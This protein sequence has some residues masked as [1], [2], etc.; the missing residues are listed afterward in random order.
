MVCTMQVGLD[1][2]SVELILARVWDLAYS[3]DC[4][5]LHGLQIAFSG[6]GGGIA[7]YKPGAEPQGMNCT[8]FNIYKQ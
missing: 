1:S 5:M 7:Y 6:I 3:N 4:V 2:C 8:T